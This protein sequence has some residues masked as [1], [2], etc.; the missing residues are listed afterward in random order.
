MF[1]LGSLLLSYVGVASAQGPDYPVMEKLAQTVVQKY[2]TS[3][4]Q[5]LAK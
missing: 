4:C 3:S 1:A 2:Q 5:D